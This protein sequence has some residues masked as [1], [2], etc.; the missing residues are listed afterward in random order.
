MKKIITIIL[1]ILLCIGAVGGS[2]ALFKHFDKETNVEKPVDDSSNSGQENPNEDNSSGGNTETPNEQPNEDIPNDGEIVSKKA[3]AWQLCTEGTEFNVG[4]QIAIV[5]QSSEYAMGNTQN[6]NNRSATIVNKNGNQMYVDEN[7]QVIT[8]EQGIV[9]NTFAFN[10]GGGYLYAASSSSNV[11]K[12][13]N[14]I[15]ENSCW[16][17]TVDSNGTA[18]IQAQG[19]ST[20]NVLMFNA[21]SKLFA[22]YSSTQNP[23]VIYKLVETDIEITPPVLKEGEILI[24]EASDFRVGETYRFYLDKNQPNS[25]VY[26]ILNLVTGDG[27]FN[28][29]YIE[30]GD[31][32]EIDL[33]NIKIGIS[34]AHEGEGYI[35]WGDMRISVDAEVSSDGDYLEIVLDESVFSATGDNDKLPTISFELMRDTECIYIGCNGGAYLVAVT[36]TAE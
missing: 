23:I 25:E 10:V 15:D 12:T 21:S 33:P 24:T 30:P 4:D 32:V 34:N 22:C 26:I 20:K 14:I 11:L 35:Y 5:A 27:G 1:S 19:T 6:T 2:F 29:W 7:M 28:G 3:N 36:D 13:H 16:A 17:L 8:L 9:E 18:N 31:T